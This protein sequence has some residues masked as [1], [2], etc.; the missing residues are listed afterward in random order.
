MNSLM[1][2]NDMPALI[3]CADSASSG[4]ECDYDD[5]DSQDEAD[6]VTREVN[7]LFTDKVF[8]SVRELFVYEAQENQFNLIDVVTRYDMGM[9]SYIKMINFIRSERPNRSVFKAQYPDESQIPWNND[10]YMKT[11]V[12]DDAALQFGK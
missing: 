9:V 5:I 7:G 8:N 3:D 4:A 10:K 6:Y 1:G 12:E 11:V 2:K